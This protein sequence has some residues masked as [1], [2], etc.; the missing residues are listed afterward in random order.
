MT[1]SFAKQSRS[2]DLYSCMQAL[3]SIRDQTCKI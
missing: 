2:A 3:I 1:D